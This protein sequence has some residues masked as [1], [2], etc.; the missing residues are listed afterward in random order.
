M[1]KQVLN[2]NVQE[3]QQAKYLSVMIDETGD[4]SNLEQISLMIR[5]TD[6]QYNACERSQASREQW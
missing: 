4:A 2:H 5:Y 6:E 3:I 1:S